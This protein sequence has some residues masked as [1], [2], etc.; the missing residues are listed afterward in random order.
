LRIVFCAIALSS[1][2]I[3]T[4]QTTTNGSSLSLR[5]G[6]TTS[7]SD[8]TLSD[9]GYVG[10]YITLSNPGPVTLTVDAS[11]TADAGAPHMNIVVADSSTG[12][13]VAP[14][15]SNYSTTVN[16]SA[17]T[18]FVRT[19]YTN[20]SP[21]TPNRQLQVRNLQV[22]GAT[23]NNSAT[24]AL[25]LSAAN[26]YIDNFRQGPATVQ[27]LSAAP[28]TSVKV[29]MTRNAFNF[30]GT[31]SGV[32]KGDSK[33]M[34]SVTNPAITT[35]AGQF[36]SF[37]N[38][39]FNAIVP[40]NGGK[41]SSNEPTQNSVNM[42]LV[43]EQLAYAQSHNMQVRMHNLLWGQTQQ[44]TW[45]N[46]LIN[47]ALSGN[48]TAAANLSTAITNRIN[49]YTGTN[50]NRSQKYIQVDGLNEALHSPT[51]WTIYGASGIASIYNQLLT[52]AAAAGNP[53]MRTVT[54]E[55]NVLQYSPATLTAPTTNFGIGGTLN[56]NATASG[57]DPYANYY[58]QEVEAI[59]NAGIASFGHR[60]VTEIG[61]EMYAD[62]NATGGNVIS[63]NTMQKALQNLSVEG[64]PLSMNEFGMASTTNSQTLGPAALENAVR[65]LYGNPLADTF[66]VWGWWD[67][68]GNTPP[69]QMIVT[70]NGASGYTLT[71]LGQKW[72]DLM[73]E[74][75]THVTPTVNADNTINFNGYYGDYALTINGQSHPYH[76]TLQKGTTN[77]SLVVLSLGDFNV[78]GQITNADLQSMLS[79]LKNPSGYESANG[80]SASDLLTIG[81]FNGDHLFN[82]ADIPGLINRLANGSGLAG[83]PEPSA[84]GLLLFGALLISAGRAHCGFTRRPD[85][86]ASLN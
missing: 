80:L 55:F 86:I 35:E 83:V 16:L 25:A 77:Y 11:G 58:R 2:A 45:V 63:T 13:D 54:N 43:D 72:V 53:N 69:A 41:W 9:N 52:A 39:Y 3:A 36:Q 68:S 60:V 61:M 50:G 8:V 31:V 10:T 14:G 20:D 64:L 56:P 7:G 23:V 38:Q 6:G 51:Y 26:T 75:S 44:P 1:V 34:L 5:S 78:D 57:S 85:S 70:A 40:S 24:D 46:T 27:L 66:M 74:F 21:T 33:D 49:Y 47:S 17:G 48:A 65:M 73:N 32:T 79:A 42:Q 67:T 28:I 22:S 84:F 37:I 15:F 30:G 4:A 71:P 81:D 62:V 19:E 76:L 12:F 82:A 59:N 29:D 18:Y